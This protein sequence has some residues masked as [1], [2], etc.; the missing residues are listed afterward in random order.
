MHDTE[1]RIRLLVAVLYFVGFAVVA[2]AA[3]A[4]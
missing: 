1:L 2:I 4:G 3:I